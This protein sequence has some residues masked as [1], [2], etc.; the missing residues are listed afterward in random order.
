M[1][2]PDDTPVGLTDR[3][4]NRLVWVLSAI[5]LI[6]ILILTPP[7]LNVNRLRRRITAS[8]SQSLGRPVAID[9]V[10]LDLLPV[11]G[12]T[13]Q[14]LVVN[15]DPAFGG[16]PVIRAQSVHARLRVGSLW[17]RQVEI[18]R[19]S[20]DEPS[21]NLVRR[22]DGH[23]N[24]E[25][26]LLHAAQEDAAP[27]VQSQAGPKPRFPYV[28]ATGARVN[29]KRGVEKLP[30]ALTEADFALW[31]PSPRQ[32]S[33]RLSG[34]P[35]RTDVTVSDTGVLTIE[36][37]LERAAQ[38]SNVAMESTIEWKRAPLGEASRLLTGKDAGWRGDVDASATAHGTFGD[39]I[40]ST[41]LR[42]ANIRRAEFIPAHRLD[43]ELDCTGHLAITSAVLTEPACTVPVGDESS[44]STSGTIAAT[45]DTV[46]LA[47]ASSTGLRIGMT[48]VPNTWFLRWLELLSERFP[49]T[50]EPRGS[51][52]GSVALVSAEPGK[53]QLWQGSFQGTTAVRPRVTPS[54]AS[55][56]EAATP[57]PRTFSIV[58]TAGGLQLLPV[59]IASAS[60][61]LPPLLLS[62]TANLQRYDL[63][64]AGTATVEELQSLAA[65]APPLADNIERLLPPPPQAGDPAAPLRI[66]IACSRSWGTEQTCVAGSV[67]EPEPHIQKHHH[68]R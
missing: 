34:K 38:L 65:L 58:P 53:P 56:A 48:T 67:P 55:A 60:R 16:E 15:D 28:E 68:G 12:F 37:T 26:I 5:L 39:A 1:R 30:M 62:G 51:I 8:I 19:I 33:V 45:A 44:S 9:N 25:S 24:V 14:N 22:A 63:Q 7:L 64:L 66:Q 35:T 18:S 47:G 50:A 59:N 52:S 54:S 57:A 23:W 21:V 17:R 27:T 6:L 2:E 29:I 41:R 10:Q 40:L 61:G 46:Q 31:L 49:A 43:V 11:P 3:E 4:R 42:L 13:L 32:W 36:A 20:F